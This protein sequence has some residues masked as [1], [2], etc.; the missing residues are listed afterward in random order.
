LL[1]SGGLDS[2]KFGADA[3]RRKMNPTLGTKTMLALRVIAGNAET[4]ATSSEISSAWFGTNGDDAVN[5]KSQYS[6]CSFNKLT[7][8]PADQGDSNSKGV[9]TVTITNNVGSDNIPIREAAVDGATDN[10]GNLPF[11]HVMVCIPPGTGSWVAYAYTNHWL[12]VYNDDWCLRVSAQMHEIGHNLGLAHSGESST[13]DDQSGMM[14]YSYSESDTKM[15]FNAPKNWQLGWYTD[16]QT[17]LIAGSSANV[18]IYGL[19]DYESTSTGDT[20]L[21][22][23]PGG[24][25]WYVSFNRKDG[26]N[27]GTKE[28]GNQVLVHNRPASPMYAESKLKAKLDAADSYSSAP[29]SITV[30]SINLSATP[31]YADVTFGDSNPTP[32]Q[33]PQ[34]NPTPKP[35]TNPTPAPQANPTPKL[36]TPAPQQQPV[37]NP[38]PVSSPVK[39]PTD[40]CKENPKT[41][42]LFKKKTNNKGNL[43]IRKKSCRWLDNKDDKTTAKFCK[44]KNKCFEGLGSAAETCPETCGSCGPCYEIETALFFRRDNGT[45]IFTKSCRWL[46]GRA[47]KNDLCEVTASGGCY[48][49]ASKVCPITCSRCTNA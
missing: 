24:T 28:G 39:S 30:N 9:H 23:I 22:Q 35:Q 14:G 44:K 37:K 34:S 10:L 42:F 49:P 45:K 8:N 11:D 48:G 43:V 18:R 15:C 21:I 33:S 38:P 1:L 17:V 26:V 6:A 20:I 40:S 29:M 36:P 16:R 46:A 7:C 25:D 47:D 31:P 13:Y 2:I 41:K 4:T 3:S 5:L 27:S 19:S 32:Q 12:S